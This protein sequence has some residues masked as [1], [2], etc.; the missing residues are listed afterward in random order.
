MPEQR[1]GGQLIESAGRRRRAARPVLVSLLVHGTLI[2][3]AIAATGHGRVYRWSRERVEAVQLARLSP[4]PPASAARDKHAPAARGFQVLQAPE[5]ST[6]LP[7]VDLIRAATVAEDFSGIGIAGGIAGG[8]AAAALSAAGPALIEGSIADDAPYLLPGQIGPDYPDVL[9]AA[10]PDGYVLVRF[11]LDTL[12]NVEPP[13][14]DVI[15]ATHPLFVT[16]VRSAME[17]LRFAPARYSGKR[18]RARM[19]QRFEFHLAAR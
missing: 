2:G 12:G 14:L 17:R 5:L 3:T 18:V 1:I 10:A 16:S 7:P 6:T 19:E 11:V 8:V 9:R 15:Q 4:A 13:T